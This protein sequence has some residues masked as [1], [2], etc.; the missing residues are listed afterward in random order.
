[1]ALGGDPGGAPGSTDRPL[2]RLVD[3]EAENVGTG[4]VARHV[5][6]ELGPGDLAH[7]QLGGEDALSVVQGTG[8]TRP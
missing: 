8:Q 3:L 5:E 1:M 4:V 2:L 6:V 7:V